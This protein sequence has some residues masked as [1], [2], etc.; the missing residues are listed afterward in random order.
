MVELLTAASPTPAS[1]VGVVFLKNYS[2]TKPW[3]YLPPLPVKMQ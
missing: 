3:F 2:Y 1:E